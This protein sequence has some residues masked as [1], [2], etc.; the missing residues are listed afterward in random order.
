LP[1]LAFA[2]TAAHGEAQESLWRLVITLQLVDPRFY[3][4]DTAVAV[5][6]DTVAFF[7]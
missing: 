5:L 4:L 7:P 2:P 3:H 6:G 1:V